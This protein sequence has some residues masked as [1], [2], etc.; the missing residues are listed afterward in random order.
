VQS[1]LGKRFHEQLFRK[2]LLAASGAMVGKLG[3]GGNGVRDRE[4][5]AAVDQTR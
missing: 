2:A 4:S 5:S 3:D 1:N